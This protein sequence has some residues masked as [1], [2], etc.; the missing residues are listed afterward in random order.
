MGIFGLFSNCHNKSILIEENCPQ[1]IYII[2][3]SFDNIAL[4]FF[5]SQLHCQL[6]K[7]FHGT[8]PHFLSSSSWEI[9]LI[10]GV[11]VFQRSVGFT[12][13]SSY[14]TKDT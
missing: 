12:D 10:E 5:I 3:V 1:H 13:F 11:P 7:V 8:F 14:N 4:V 2:Q 6:L 9:V